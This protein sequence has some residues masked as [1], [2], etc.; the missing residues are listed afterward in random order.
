[1]GEKRLHRT[2]LHLALQE[3]L[4]GHRVLV[5]RLQ[6]DRGVAFE[7]PSEHGPEAPLPERPF[8]DVH[9]D[10]FRLHPRRPSQHFRRPAAGAIKSSFIGQLVERDPRDQTLKP[11]GG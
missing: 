1:M 5:R 2:H 11:S 6:D 7:R 4:R 3:L 10:V 8:A 9:A